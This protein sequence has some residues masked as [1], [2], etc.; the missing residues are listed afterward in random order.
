MIGL[1]LYCRAPTAYGLC[2]PKAI[3]L[4]LLCCF[5]VMVLLAVP[6]LLGQAKRTLPAGLATVH[7]EG[8][9]PLPCNPVSQPVPQCPRI[10]GT[11]G[12]EGG[13]PPAR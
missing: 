1:L 7:T 9:V 4:L 12:Q 11:P 2:S 3:L 10:C 5:I 6:T 8:L 13:H